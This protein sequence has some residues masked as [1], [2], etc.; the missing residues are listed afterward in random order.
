MYQYIRAIL[1][2]INHQGICLDVYF[3]KM[4]FEGENMKAGRHQTV[5]EIKTEGKAYS[6]LH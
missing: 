2:F 1:K 6:F 3:G 5:H 4:C